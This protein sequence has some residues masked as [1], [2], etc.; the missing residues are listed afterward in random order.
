MTSDR[1][2]YRSRCHRLLFVQIHCHRCAFA[3]FSHPPVYPEVCDKQKSDEILWK[4][5][6]KLQPD[7]LYQDHRPGFHLKLRQYSRLPPAW[8]LHVLTGFQAFQPFS[9]C[10]VHADIH[11]DNS[12]AEIPSP[13]PSVFFRALICLQYAAVSAAF[14]LPCPYCS[15]PA[16]LFAYIVKVRYQPLEHF[17]T[18]RKNDCSL[19]ECSDSFA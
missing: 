13:V 16:W 1:R 10:G 5:H 7:I 17:L 4:S 18:V 19:W 3:V 15:C 9:E 6:W 2:N 11:P 8:I 14:Y 12:S